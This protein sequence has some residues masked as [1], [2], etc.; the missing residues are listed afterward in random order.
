MRVDGAAKVS[1]I[2]FSNG[3]SH[4][5]VALRVQPNACHPLGW[6]LAQ[7]KEPQISSEGQNVKP[8]NHSVDSDAKEPHVVSPEQ[9]PVEMPAGPTHEEIRQRAYEIHCERGYA[10]GQDL[11]DW[12]QAERELKAKSAIG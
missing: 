12:L 10:H 6:L 11:E 8:K 1:C 9:V 3:N 2:F 4:H 5:S 7:N